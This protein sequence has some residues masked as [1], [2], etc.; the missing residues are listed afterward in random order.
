MR[1]CYY[2]LTLSWHSVLSPIRLLNHDFLSI[3]NID[4]ML[5]RLL[6]ILP[7]LQV[8]PHTI[9]QRRW[10]CYI[11][12]AQRVV[13]GSAISAEH[14]RHIKAIKRKNFFIVNYKFK[15][16]NYVTTI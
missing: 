3:K 1:M 16:V 14:N 13:Q 8:I 11:N 9:F 12:H 2:T 5:C 15:I 7:A 6:N 10:D 4:T